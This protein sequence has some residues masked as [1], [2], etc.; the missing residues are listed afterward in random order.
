M[1]TFLCNPHQLESELLEPPTKA[2]K[3]ATLAAT[4]GR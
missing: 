4:V 2:A 3:Q 1:G